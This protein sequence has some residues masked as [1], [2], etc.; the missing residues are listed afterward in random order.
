MDKIVDDTGHQ[1]H[2]GDDKKDIFVDVPSREVK[3]A[4]DG[5]SSHGEIHGGSQKRQESRLIGQYRPLEGKPF[6]QYQIFVHVSKGTYSRIFSSTLV[7]T[8]V[9]CTQI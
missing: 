4:V 6:A 8:K 7:V 2:S 9:T 5:N 3:Q 1:N